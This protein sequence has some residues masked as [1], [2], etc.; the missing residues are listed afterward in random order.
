MG[1]NV[2]TFQSMPFIEQHKVLKNL[3]QDDMEESNSTN[4]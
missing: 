4:L 3:I 2:S 1:V